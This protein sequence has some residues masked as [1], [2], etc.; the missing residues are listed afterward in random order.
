MTENSGAKGNIFGRVMAP[1]I[2]AALGAQMA[3]KRTNEATLNG[4][5]ITI[6]CAKYG[7]TSVGATPNVLA[8]VTAVYGAFQKKDGTFEILSLSAGQYKNFMYP[9]RSTGAVNGST[10]MVSRSDFRSAGTIIHP[11]L[12]VSLELPPPPPLS[13]M[14]LLLKEIQGQVGSHPIGRLH[15]IRQAL[16]KLKK[17][18]AKTTFASM[19]TKEGWAYHWGG[20]SE[21]QFNLGFEDIEGKAELRHGVAFSFEPSD[22]YPDLVTLLAPKVRLF[23]EFMTIQPESWSDF[24]MWHFQAG[25]R[26]ADYPVGPIPPELARPDVFVFLGRRQD[27]SDLNYENLLADLDRLLPLYQ[28]VEGGGHLDR[29]PLSGDQ[30]FSFRPGCPSKPGYATATPVERIINLDLRHNRLQE[31][32]H[33]ALV[34]E[35]G[36][37]NV[38]TEVRSGVGNHVD[39]MVQTSEGYWFYEIKTETTARACLR[40][41]L[42]QI[43]E[44]AYWPGNQ[45]AC[46]LII[47]GEPPLDAAGTTYLDKLRTDFQLPLDYLQLPTL[48]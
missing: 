15:E 45:T 23:N 28:F 39:V 25:H 36:A 29:D 24:R 13:Q 17:L 34:R 21:L 11:G 5:S 26:S 2:A 32:L 48:E 19:F 35:H 40:Q 46:R 42:G 31:Q 12:S 38:G 16:K 14:E 3:G 22:S 44:Y 43:L 41:A 47:A 37:K 30:G 20:R 6:K 10:Q 1:R 33:A 18:P 8:R 9:S 4:Q 7:S 27:L